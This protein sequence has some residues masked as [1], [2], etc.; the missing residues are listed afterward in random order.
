MSKTGKS[1]EQYIAETPLIEINELK[2]RAKNGI[3]E[4]QRPFVWKVLCGYLPENVS[5]HSS[6]QKVKRREYC[7]LVQYHFHITQ[8]NYPKAWKSVKEQIKKDI[9]RTY[10][11]PFKLFKCKEFGDVIARISVVWSFE[12]A[13]ILFFQ[14][15]LDWVSLFFITYLFEHISFKDAIEITD[16]SSFT[17]KWILQV[18]T[19]C[20][21]SLCATLDK[22][23]DLLVSDFGRIFNAVKV[24]ENIVQKYDPTLNQF[25]LEY[26]E[27]YLTSTR[28]FICPFTRNFNFPQMYY[29]FDAMLSTEMFYSHFYFVA[30]LFI[31]NEEH[32]MKDSDIIEV[33]QAVQSLPTKTWDL[34]K[35]KIYISNALMMYH[36]DMPSKLEVF[37]PMQDPIQIPPYLKHKTSQLTLKQLPY[38]DEITQTLFRYTIALVLIRFF[39]SLITVVIVVLALI[40]KHQTKLSL[41]T[42]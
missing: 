13:D 35:I 42:F 20:Y 39:I 15:L 10:L 8:K 40:I 7:R 22:Y 17:P 26:P 31:E 3:P 30:G 4:K 29:I 9:P 14:G 21:Y 37:L 33:M 27:L 23:R 16:L 41:K 1:L 38:L 24:L 2:Q 25:I 19:D 5:L 12:H 6:K 36:N 28:S 34:Q 18:E 11:K 32:I